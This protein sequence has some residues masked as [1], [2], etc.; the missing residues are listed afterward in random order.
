MKTPRHII[1][2]LAVIVAIATASFANAADKKTS[3]ATFAGGCFWCMESPYDHINGVKATVSGYT[4]GTTKNPTYHQVGSGKTGHTESIQ[5]EFDPSK[6]TYGQLL[7][8][9]WHNIDPTD[10]D[11]Q[12]CDRGSQ[13]RPEI[14]YHDAAQKA[15]AEASRAEVQKKF[16]SVA[17]NVTA[18]STFYPAEEY[19]QD[20]CT[21]EP[22]NYSRYRSGCGRD[23]RL[24]ELWGNEAGK[25]HATK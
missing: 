1:P 18:A 23:R 22:E 17:V 21:K 16:G 2:A 24:K 14:F 10:G 13:Y 5:V 8:V 19:H 7:Q 6:V 3:I 4:G 9:Y 20:Y 12:F 15:A 25:A 11:G